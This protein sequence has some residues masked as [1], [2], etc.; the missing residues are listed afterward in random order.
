MINAIIVDDEAAA[1][2]SLERLLSQYCPEVKVVGRAKSAGEARKQIESQDPQ[3]VFLD[4]EMPYESG[5]DLLEG[6]KTHP[7]EVI[8]ITGFEKYALKAIRL[9]ACD[10]LLKP[11]EIDEMKTAVSIATERVT[12][13]AENLRLKTLLANSR[14]MD[15]DMKIALPSLHGIS[16]VKIMDIIHCEAEGRYTWFYFTNREK[17]LVTKNLGEFE[18]LLSSNNFVRIHHAHLINAHHISEFIKG[19]SP[20]L[21]M[22]DGSSIMVSQRRRDA[23]LKLLMDTSCWKSH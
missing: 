18:E 23:P 19:N 4:V 2:E 22:T 1:I 7:F 10:Y 12:S 5:L 15:K 14:A 13:K 6:Y 17:L 21:I 16:F 9:S 11:V 8:F 20:T 3:L